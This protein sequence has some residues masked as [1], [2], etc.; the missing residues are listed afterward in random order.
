M[1]EELQRVQNLG[2]LRRNRNTLSFFNPLVLA[3]FAALRLAHIIEEED[4]G[5]NIAVERLSGDINF[6]SKCLELL[7]DLTAEDITLLRER[8]F[9]LEGAQQ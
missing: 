5:L 3:Y 1:G 8:F 6:W 2:I 4:N 9:I 7:A